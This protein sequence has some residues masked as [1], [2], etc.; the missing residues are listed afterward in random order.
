MRLPILRPL[1]HRDFLLLFVGQTVSIAGN[2]LY[3]VALPFQILA[4]GGSAFQLGTGFSI[5]AAAQLVTILFSGALVDRLP[6]RAVILSMDALSAVVV[7]TVAALGFA[8]RLEITHLYVLS[9][10][11]GATFAFY[12]PA[13]SAIMPEL[14]PADVL[15]QGNAL[16]GLGRQAAAV[17]GPLAGGLVVS[18][19][20]PPAAFAIDAATFAFSFAVFYF[21][22][23]PRREH[24]PGPSLVREIREGFA[25]TFSVSWIW[26]A[27]VGFAATN[28]FFFAGLTVALPILVLNVL[29]GSA[30]TYGLI[31]AAQGLGQIAG[32]LLVGNLHF[33]KLVVGTYVF[34]AL[35]GL[36]FAV[37]GIAPVVPVVMLGGF[38]FSFCIVASNTHWDSS[39]QSFVPRQLLGRVTSID[40]FGS[41][42]VGPVAPLLAAAALARVAPG[43]IFVIGGLV[44]FAY[45]AV[46]M[47]VTRPDRSSP[48]TAPAAANK[49]DS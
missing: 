13:L 17:V 10:F 38:L 31:G 20:G 24:V 8:H 4:L 21:S 35:L 32:G 29:K 34:S 26:I 33:K 12:M 15:V 28:G 2:A 3:F 6:R 45:W 27:I 42:L 16:R 39:L 7:A 14:I 22:R 36:S 49:V 23:P 46:A 18:T 48:L 47:A 40:W 41:Y 37:F 11:F 44:T 30:A 43:W 25:Y 19:H 9:G 1:R 5:F